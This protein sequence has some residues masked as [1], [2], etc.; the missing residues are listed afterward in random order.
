MARSGFFAPP[1]LSRFKV[2][3][4]ILDKYL[5]GFR[6]GSV[7]ARG[8]LTSNSGQAYAVRLDL[9]GFPTRMPE[10]F[11]TSPVLVMANGQMLNLAG[12]SHA[13]HVLG[14][15]GEGNPRICHWHEDAWTPSHTL[16]QVLI[17]VRIWLEAWEAHLRT[18]LPVSRWLPTV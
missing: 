13:M 18:G 7:T 16:Y 10:A 3:Q 1:K 12:G 2:E 14:C 11:I 9:P 5:P 4:T 15:D 17:K 6:I 8:M